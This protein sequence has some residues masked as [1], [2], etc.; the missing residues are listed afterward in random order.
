MWMDVAWPGVADEETPRLPSGRDRSASGAN[1]EM[2]MAV[3]RVT[4]AMW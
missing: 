4:Q 1:K 2:K 3:H